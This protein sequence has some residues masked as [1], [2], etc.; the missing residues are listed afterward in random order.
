V[1]KHASHRTVVLL[2]STPLIIIFKKSVTI[3]LILQKL[4]ITPEKF[5]FQM[6][7]EDPS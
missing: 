4:T 5:K 7:I 6:L 1:R 3:L 2:N